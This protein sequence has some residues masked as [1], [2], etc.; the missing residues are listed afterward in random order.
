MGDG[1]GSDG[2]SAV[3][4]GG[5]LLWVVEGSVRGII[6]GSLGLSGS[7]GKTSNTISHSFSNFFSIRGR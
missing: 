3:V 4:C 2:G 6:A 1:G 5:V 7:T